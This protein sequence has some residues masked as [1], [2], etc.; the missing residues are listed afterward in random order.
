V[1]VSACLCVCTEAADS[2]IDVGDAPQEVV[3][4]A[5]Q[6]D[7]PARGG[8]G[9]LDAANPRHRSRESGARGHQWCPDADAS[10]PAGNRGVDSG[11]DLFGSLAV[12][13]LKVTV[14]RQSTHGRE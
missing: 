2:V 14:D 9:G 8:G 7:L 6:D 1:D 4:T 3:R 11:P 12:T 10:E 5:G 13:V